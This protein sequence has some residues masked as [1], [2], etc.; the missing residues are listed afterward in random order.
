MS[1]EQAI[2]LL[3]RYFSLPTINRTIGICD[4]YNKGKVKSIE[5]HGEL[6]IVWITYKTKSVAYKYIGK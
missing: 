6:I 1:K 3:Q 5:Y 4:K 2:H